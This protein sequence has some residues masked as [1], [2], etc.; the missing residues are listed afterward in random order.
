MSGVSDAQ[1]DS[2]VHPRATLSCSLTKAVAPTYWRHI[3]VNVTLVGNI[4]S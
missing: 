2:A 4:L 1:P 3:F